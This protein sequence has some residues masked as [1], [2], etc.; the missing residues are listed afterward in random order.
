MTR[1]L[2][3]PTLTTLTP[4][5]DA[6]RQLAISVA[7]SALDGDHLYEEDTN[8]GFVVNGGMALEFSANGTAGVGTSIWSSRGPAIGKVRW[9]NKSEPLNIG[10]GGGSGHK[11]TTS[12]GA[13][14][15]VM[16]DGRFAK[17]ENGGAYDMSSYK[18]F[19][20]FCPCAY[21]ESVRVWF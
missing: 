7:A 12:L 21:R 2:P 13:T 4:S 20:K 3:T 19:R 14:M 11:R 6:G 1:Q 15:T 17:G 8:T 16:M 18:S 10:G 9:E 5:L